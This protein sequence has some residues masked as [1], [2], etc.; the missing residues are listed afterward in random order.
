MA[1]RALPAHNVY[2]EVAQ[3][4]GL[5]GLPIYLAFLVSILRRLR[6]LP[7]RSCS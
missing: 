2:I 3:E 5:V 4:L 6:N 7:T 1:G